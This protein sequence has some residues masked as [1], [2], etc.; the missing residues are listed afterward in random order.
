MGALLGS[1]ASAS[2]SW[3][4]VC[5]L[6]GVGRLFVVGPT[7]DGVW[8]Q[9][10][11]VLSNNP[12]LDNSPVLWLSN[13]K[14]PWTLPGRCLVLKTKTAAR[15]RTPT[16]RA[17]VMTHSMGMAGSREGGTCHPTVLPRPVALLCYL[18]V[19]GGQT[20]RGSTPSNRITFRITH[21]TRI[22]FILK[23]QSVMPSIWLSPPQKNFQ[24]G[25]IRFRK[26]K[27]FSEE[28]GPQGPASSVLVR[29]LLRTGDRDR[30]LRFCGNPQQLG[31]AAFTFADTKGALEEGRLSQERQGGI[32]GRAALEMT[33]PPLLA[34]ALSMVRRKRFHTA[35]RRPVSE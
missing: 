14:S 27:N 10:H 15:T 8:H 26:T 30:P 29:R 32:P 5:P 3:L 2:G 11:F 21:K 9:R 7:W 1:R 35:L 34:G 22:I 28:A 18:Q 12:R 4:A 13:R 33:T 19:A 24:H 17:A 25:P 6:L 20:Q 23:Y 16:A 31:N